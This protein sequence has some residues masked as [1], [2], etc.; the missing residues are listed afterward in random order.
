MNK[1][2]F[3]VGVL[4]ALCLHARE[5]ESART[6]AKQVS[7][8]MGGVVLSAEQQR[9]RKASQEAEASMV[10]GK[11]E[12]NA[13]IN[14][15]YDDVNSV[16]DI[17]WLDIKNT[18]AAGLSDMDKNIQT[19][20]TELTELMEKEQE[21]EKAAKWSE[22]S[23]SD[24][25]EMLT[26][27]CQIDEFKQEK[28]AP[29]CD[30]ARDFQC[31]WHESFDETYPEAEIPY[32]TPVKAFRVSAQTKFETGYKRLTVGRFRKHC[33]TVFKSEEGDEMCDDL[34]T[35]F[36]NTVSELS[37]SEAGA[38]NLS[39][40]ETQD[41]II[42]KIAAKKTELQDA[43]QEKEA[44]KSQKAGID[45][46]STQL[47]K[48][49]ATVNAG[50][51][52]VGAY[53]RELKK[54]QMKLKRAQALFKA[55]QQKLAKA[56]TIFAAAAEK[57]AE[58]SAAVEVQEKLLK[59]LEEAYNAQLVL[60]AELAKKVQEIEAATVAGQEFKEHLSIVLLN[61]VDLNSETYHTPLRKIGVTPGAKIAQEFD[62]ADVDSAP[63]MKATVQAVGEFCK[64][65]VGALSA[66]QTQLGSTTHELAFICTGVD[67]GN[68][69]KEAEGVVKKDAQEIVDILV[70]E[71]ENVNADNR[72]PK[73]AD[74]TREL[75]EAH[76]EPKGLRQ[77]VAIYGGG[78]STFV[79]TYINPGWAVDEKEKSVQLI[80][81]MLMLYQKL[82]EAFEATTEKWEQAKLGAIE[83]EKQVQEAIGELKKLSEML[84]AAIAEKDIA[85]KDMTSA[86]KLADQAEHARNALVVSVVDA[87]KSKDKGDKAFKKAEE[88][89]MSEHRDRKVALLEILQELQE[90]GK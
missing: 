25:D 18:A 34:C 26:A 83:L 6:V 75:R 72:I 70:G 48:L 42:I 3:S 80:G 5:A 68:M 52:A 87:T 64:G 47:G 38:I 36:A 41:G 11:A 21:L 40:R 49:G 45:K 4:V 22:V 13:K 56:K 33:A 23:D 31:G 50:K 58:R 86:Q 17:P 43:L 65:K 32:E 14:V 28:G 89:L 20:T 76:G 82:G 46:L 57:V 1:F 69:I 73:Q 67:W 78:T 62:K 19:L 44:C 55:M 77:A 54:Q 7:A 12:I 74:L 24:M 9:L 79:N 37:A 10:C 35:A 8:Q 53:K 60:M 71:L 16:Q 84:Q 29:S 81:N 66:V 27:A 2:L 39:E 30:R 61:T 51:T 90:K 15:A 59:K 63:A 88:I 85:E